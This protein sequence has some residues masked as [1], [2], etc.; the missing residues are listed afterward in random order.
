VE[1]DRFRFIL[2]GGRIQAVYAPTIV[3]DRLFDFIPEEQ[4]ELAPLL[5][6]TLSEQLDPSM[7]GLVRLLE[8]SL[9]D[10]RRLRSLLRSQSAILTYWALTADAGRFQFEPDVTPPPMFQA[11]PLQLSLPAL[12]VEGVRRCAPTTDV[13]AMAGL[14]FTRQTPKGGHLDRSGLSPSEMRIYTLFDGTCD[15]RAVAE[16]LGAELEMV[17]DLAR[18]LEL[19]GLA[20]RRSESAGASVLVLEDDAEA[21]RVLQRT[22]GNEG[23]GCQIKVVRDK[24]G[25]QLLLRRGRFDLVLLNLDR[26]E[27]EP[28]VQTCKEQCPDTT[29]IVGIVG[30]GD[31]GEAKLSR[32][33]ALALDGILHRPIS[34]GDLNATMDHLLDAQEPVEVA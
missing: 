18:G 23:R 7:T 12:A 34:E 11:F 24:A 20:E 30:F 14:V 29:R 3:P 16:R 33:D 13:E 6:A 8:R 2:S 17:A 9:S 19:T 27:L 4:T 22:L 28:F 31:D 5:S 10:P 21:V 25:A 32:L 1:K 15:L 26:P